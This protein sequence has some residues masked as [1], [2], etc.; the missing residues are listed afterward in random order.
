LTAG[1]RVE[2]TP[3]ARRDIRQRHPAVR[4]RWDST[5]RAGLLAA[6]PVVAL[7]LLAAARDKTEFTALAAALDALPQGPVTTAPAARAPSTWRY[8]P[9][10]A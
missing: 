7:E 10:C 4:P 9:K 6:C 8:A 5:L 3:P 1:W 2:I